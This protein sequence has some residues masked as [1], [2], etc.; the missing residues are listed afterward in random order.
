MPSDN[1][2][3]LKDIDCA[4]RTMRQALETRRFFPMPRISKPK[5]L[6][7]EVRV[8]AM[9]FSLFPEPANRPSESDHSYVG[10]V[11]HTFVPMG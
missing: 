9:P 1:S 4:R 8:F 5:V 7:E 11:V 6:R 2:I 10:L 3:I